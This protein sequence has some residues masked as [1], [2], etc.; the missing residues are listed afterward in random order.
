MTYSKNIRFLR[1][2]CKLS[3]EDLAI[4]LGVKRHTICDWETARTEPNVTHLR[5]LAEIFNVTVNYIVGL[6]EVKY[7]EDLGFDAQMDYMSFVAKNDL[8]REVMEL[9]SSCNEEQ[10]ELIQHI[11]DGTKLF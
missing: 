5:N 7:S 11:L 3:Q 8:E 4:L 9:I 2:S 10:L 6:D 1:K